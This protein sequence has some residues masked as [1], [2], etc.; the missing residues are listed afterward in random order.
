M[1]AQLVQQCSCAAGTE[2]Q[3]NGRAISILNPNPL[4]IAIA[5]LTYTG[6]L[7]NLIS[8]DLPE[9]APYIRP[10]SYC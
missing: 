8:L 6:G 9:S 2:Y 5:A 1:L 4:M 10:F 7:F 3:E